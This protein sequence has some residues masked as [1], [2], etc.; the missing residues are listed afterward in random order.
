MGNNNKSRPEQPF[1]SDNNYKNHSESNTIIKS[2]ICDNDHNKRA[3]SKRTISTKSKQNKYVPGEYIYDTKGQMAEIKY[4]GQCHKGSGVWYG[5]EFVDGS[6]GKH[7]GT[8]NGKM[9]F[10][11]MD[12]R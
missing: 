1:V 8:I 7:N 11:G 5:I 3:K 10:Y 12:R 9:Y 2:K 6:L 4:I